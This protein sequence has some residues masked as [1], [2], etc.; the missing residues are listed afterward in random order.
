MKTRRKAQTRR[1]GKFQ[2]EELQSTI[3]P[4]SIVLRRRGFDFGTE[5]PPVYYQLADSTI[6]KYV[7]AQMFLENT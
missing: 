2:V 5:I 7:F 3:P 1:E 6:Q 4:F